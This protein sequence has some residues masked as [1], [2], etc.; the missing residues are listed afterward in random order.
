MRTNQN[1]S[2]QLIVSVLIRGYSQCSDDI[3]LYLT[4]YNGN[5]LLLTSNGKWDRAERYL[6]L[7]CL[8]EWLVLVKFV[9]FNGDTSR[10]MLINSQT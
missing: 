7:L 2:H 3:V 10:I 5:Q 6:T 9:L 8:T 1:S 4:Q